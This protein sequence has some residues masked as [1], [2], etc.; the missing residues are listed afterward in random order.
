MTEYPRSSLCRQLLWVKRLDALHPAV[1]RLI[2]RVA[3]A[4]RERDRHVGV[5]GG[6]GSD[7]RALPIL[8]GL[9]IREVSAVPAAI[10]ELKRIA[11]GLDTRACAELAKRALALSSAA[12]VRALVDA[13]SRER[14]G[15]PA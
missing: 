5:C 11:R 14:S 7:P 12:D 10:P 3:D 6:L 1:L 4:G 8:M 15:T 2:A 9:G 13:W